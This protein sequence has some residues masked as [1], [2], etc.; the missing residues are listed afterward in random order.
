MKNPNIELSRGDIHVT[1]CNHLDP[2]D[3]SL[4]MLPY[5][6]ACSGHEASKRQSGSGTNTAFFSV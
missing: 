2:S 3:P 4:I 6:R 1:T 5:Q